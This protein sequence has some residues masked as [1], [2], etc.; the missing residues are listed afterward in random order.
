MSERRAPRWTTGTWR[1][2]PNYV[3]TVDG[4]LFA[5]LDIGEM[6]KHAKKQHPLASEGAKPEDLH[7]LRGVNFETD[8]AA[9]HAIKAGLSARDFDGITPTGATGG[10]VVADVKAAAKTLNR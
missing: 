6:R 3:C 5:T 10:F 9:E 7:P 2:H 1:G 8:R 4:C